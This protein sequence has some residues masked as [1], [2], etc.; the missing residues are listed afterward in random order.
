MQWE[1][2]QNLP[3]SRRIPSLTLTGNV[4]RRSFK[5]QF[6]LY[7]V[8][9]GVYTKPEARKVALLLKVAGPE[10]IEVYNTFVFNENK[11]RNKLDDV[12][13]K[14]TAHCSPKKNETYERYVSFTC[15]AAAGNIW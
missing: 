13:A 4:D 11:D 7:T 1:I 9:I 10:A 15:A 6:E 14:F 5:Q 12:L 8:A 3:F 2:F